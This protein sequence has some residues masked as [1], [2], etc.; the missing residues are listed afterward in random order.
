MFLQ[1]ELSLK[2]DPKLRTEAQK[3]FSD[4]TYLLIKAEGFTYRNYL[5]GF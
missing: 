1:E 5:N 4:G 3:W 2:N